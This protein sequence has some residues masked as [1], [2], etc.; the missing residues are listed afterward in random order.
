MTLQAWRGLRAAMRGQFTS[1]AANTIKTAAHPRIKVGRH[2]AL[3]KLV[4][5]G[6]LLTGSTGGEPRPNPSKCLRGRD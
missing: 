6:H 5:V 3:Q 4:I 1:L 2:A